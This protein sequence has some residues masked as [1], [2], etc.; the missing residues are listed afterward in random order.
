MRKPIE[1]RWTGSR[2]ES[3]GSIATIEEDMRLAGYLPGD[4]VRITPVG[5]ANDA[6]DQ[7]VAA[8]RAVGWSERHHMMEK[9]HEEV[10]HACGD[11][12]PCACWNDE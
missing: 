12:L 6:V 8:L 2:L 9:L 4:I 3:F 1:A 7:F 10:C 11:E 5:G